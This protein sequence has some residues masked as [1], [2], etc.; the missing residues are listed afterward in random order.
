MDRDGNLTVNYFSVNLSLFINLLS[1]KSL[2]F[3]LIRIQISKYRLYFISHEIQF[4]FLLLP[5]YFLIEF[6]QCYIYEK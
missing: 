6:N 5:T 4:F 2:M 3:I 1:F